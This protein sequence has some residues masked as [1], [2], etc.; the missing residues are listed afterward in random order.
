MMWSHFLRR[1]PEALR[2]IIEF[3]TELKLKNANMVKFIRCN[4]LGE[5]QALKQEMKKKGLNLQ[6]EFTAP[7]TP[8]EN[9]KVERAFAT[10]WGRTRAMLNQAQL[11][12]E[13][14]NGL[15]AECAKCATQL[16]NIIVKPG[17]EKSPFEK[18]YKRKP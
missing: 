2:K 10:L 17:E 16:N 9:G 1:K 18:F 11:D 4:N 14:R 5:N 7:G 13:L 15:W 8:Q 12:D 3:V 6:F